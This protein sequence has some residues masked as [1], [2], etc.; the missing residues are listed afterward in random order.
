MYQQNKSSEFKVKF[1]QASNQ[2]KRILKAAKLLLKQEFITSQKLGSWDF[3][4]IFNSV[5]NKGKYTTL[6]L[7]NGLE[8]LSSLSD[9]AK[10]F[11]KNFSNNSNLDVSGISLPVFPSK[12]NLKLHNI[13]VT[14]KR[15]QK[16]IMNLDSS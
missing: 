11:A 2:Y 5:L 6:L 10:L 3:W 7:L 4:P 9:K 12:T 16:V 13:S 1:R 8:V 15:V 14:P